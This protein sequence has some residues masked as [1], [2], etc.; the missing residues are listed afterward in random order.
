MVHSTPAVHSA[1]TVHSTLAVHNKRAGTVHSTQLVHFA[2]TVHY[3]PAVHSAGT[4][5]TT[6][7]G[8]V[9]G[10][11]LST[12]QIWYTVLQFSQCNIMK[13]YWCITEVFHVVF[14]KEGFFLTSVRTL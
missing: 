13:I 5:H 2:D 10:T 1:G 14:H 12:V 4:V 8:P 11:Q 7:A 9:N 6:P 3:T